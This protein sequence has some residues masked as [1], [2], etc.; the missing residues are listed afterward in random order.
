[1]T[2]LLCPMILCLSALLEAADGNSIPRTLRVTGTIQAVHSIDLRVP[3]VQGVGSNITLT[4]L[5]QNG[6]RV[7]SGELIAEFDPTAE[8]RAAR[9]AGAKFD[10]LA[11]QVDQK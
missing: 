6:A 10:D 2:R 9:E 7:H 4:H 3:S 5:I 8:I 1:M 11:H